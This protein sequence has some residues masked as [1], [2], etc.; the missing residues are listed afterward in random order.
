MIDFPPRPTNY[1]NKPADGAT[2]DEWDQY[3]RLTTS[4]VE[5]YRADLDAYWI[6][7]QIELNSG[8]A[9]VPPPTPFPP[10]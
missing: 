9:P 2:A 7:K 1:P 4:L 6:A 5:R 8:P 10:P 3:S